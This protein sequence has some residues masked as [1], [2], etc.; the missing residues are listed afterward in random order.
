MEVG[1]PVTGV[2]CFFAGQ[3]A[4]GT[5][6]QECTATMQPV[7]ASFVITMA[8]SYCSVFSGK[9]GMGGDTNAPGTACAGGKSEVYAF[10]DMACQPTAGMFNLDAGEVAYVECDDKLCEGCTVLNPRS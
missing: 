3:S 9:P 10:H 5:E 1:K 4:S 2:G 7:G 6:F 8:G